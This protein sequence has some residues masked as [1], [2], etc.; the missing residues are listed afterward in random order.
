M[1]A[2]QTFS[3]EYLQRCKGLTIEEKLDFI[4]NFRLMYAT[5][6]PPSKAVDQQMPANPSTKNIKHQLD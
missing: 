4:E 5:I 3:D 6:H 2:L 1:K